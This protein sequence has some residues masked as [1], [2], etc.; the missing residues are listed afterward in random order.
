[1]A[2]YEWI[3][4]NCVEGASSGCESIA[5]SFK[6]TVEKN[7]EIVAKMVDDAVADGEVQH[8]FLIL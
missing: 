5:E 7:P 2:T 4:L 6:C 8:Y 1:M 3:L